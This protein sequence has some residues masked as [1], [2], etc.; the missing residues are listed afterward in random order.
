MSDDPNKEQ[1]GAIV[2]A[3]MLA[4]HKTLSNFARRANTEIERLTTD[5]H[6]SEL[7][8][9]RGVS[10]GWKDRE[11]ARIKLRKGTNLSWIDRITS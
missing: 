3:R 2:K 6:L 4:F 7:I 8:S 11:N 9:H 1:F 5:P 10:S